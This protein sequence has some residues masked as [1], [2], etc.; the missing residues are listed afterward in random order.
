MSAPGLVFRVIDTGQRGGR[1]NMA[2]DQALIELHVE[3][4][5]PDTIRFLQFSPCVLVGRHQNL[6]EEVDLDYCA[7]HGVEVGRR[8]TGGGAL[9]LD[10]SQFGW[11]LVF[12]RATLG[13]RDLADAARRICEAA[14]AG[15][16]QLGIPVHYRPRNDLEIDGRK[17][18]GTGGFF[19][20]DTLF[21]QGTVLLDCDAARMTHALRVPAAKLAKRALTEAAARMIGLNQALGRP[22]APA[23]AKAALLRGFADNLG[24]TLQ[25]G[26]IGQQ[27]E[28]RAAALLQ[29][30]IGTEDFVHGPQAPAA[31]HASAELATAGGRLRV[32][33]RLEGPDRGLIREALITGDFFVTPPRI[34]YDLEA[35]LRGSP[36]ADAPHAI[37]HLLAS[38][39]ATCLGFTPDDLARAADQAL[40]GTA[41]EGCHD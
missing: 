29:D 26:G 16:S 22:V 34:I 1:A 18:G 8:V 11:E 39:S 14:A 40:R 28:A 2:F 12:N 20:N 10:P 36:A 9:Y 19:D 30:E 33:F 3:R 6:A 27:E 38:R 41:A 35:S 17:V 32:D 23:D 15:L 4:R 37:R 25:L 21:Y 31:P 5:I 13:V 7:E 24:L